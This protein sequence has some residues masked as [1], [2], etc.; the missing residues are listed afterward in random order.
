MV[1]EFFRAGVVVAVVGA[2][3]LV[4][5]PRHARAADE[6]IP[7]RVESLPGATC[8]SGDPFATQLLRRTDRIREAAGDESAVVFRLEVEPGKDHA[9]GRLTVREP[10]GSETEREVVG[11]S[12]Q[13]VVS[14][15]VL[16]A[17]VLLDPNA[18]LEPLA[19][20]SPPPPKPPSPPPPPRSLPVEP[21]ESRP[22]GAVIPAGRRPPPGAVVRPRSTR[23]AAERQRS[24]S[25]SIAPGS[26]SAT[27]SKRGDGLLDRLAAGA[28]VGLAL[29][30]APLPKLSA[31][32][33]IVGTA[34]LALESIFSP[35][36]EA[37]GVRTQTVRVGTPSGVADFRFSSVR[38]L[39]CPV[40][41]PAKSSIALRP[42]A[43]AELGELEGIG[44]V[45]RDPAYVTA[46]WVAVGGLG[47]L[48]VTLVGPLALLVQGGVVVPLIRHEFYFDPDG[49][50][51]T[52]LE[53][54]AAGFSSRLGVVAEFE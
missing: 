36:L 24:P 32:V 30:G 42:C 17:A 53:V 13:E 29:E 9:S 49:P 43:L 19:P 22:P 54:P 25:D 28:G 41:F 47:R 39:A 20:P 46:R 15:M 12:C 34:S 16:I 5:V 2:I 48:S 35:L 1:A 18:S 10:D 11:A 50:E 26:S 4:A 45:T 23:D 8:P 6:P 3:A 52:A 14:A 40:R 31:G 7:F 38:L 51:T 44:K 33:A 27:G 37:S 21:S